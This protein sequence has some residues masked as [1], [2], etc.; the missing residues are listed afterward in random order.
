MNEE[1]LL[2]ALQAWAAS[3]GKSVT[4]IQ[5]YRKNTTDMMNINTRMLFPLVIGGGGVEDEDIY[6]LTSSFSVRMIQWGLWLGPR[7]AR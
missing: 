5:S 1:T 3:T 7:V 6:A 4:M 2:Q